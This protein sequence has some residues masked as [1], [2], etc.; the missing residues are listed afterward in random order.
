MPKICYNSH[1]VLS[2]E[3]CKFFERILHYQHS[4]TFYTDSFRM[5]SELRVKTCR[6]L[7][8]ADFMLCWTLIAQ[9]L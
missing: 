5:T 4:A 1:Y 6:A 8:S 7:V 3:S 9:L 2:P